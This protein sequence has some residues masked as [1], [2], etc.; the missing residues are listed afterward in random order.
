[1]KDGRI[2]LVYSW[3]DF[4]TRAGTGARRLTW[5]LE[6]AGTDSRR[7]MQKKPQILFMIYCLIKRRNEKLL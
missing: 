7:R 3:P 1:M 4:A 2:E 5:R 6:A